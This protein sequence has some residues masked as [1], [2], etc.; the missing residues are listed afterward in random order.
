MKNWSIKNTFRY[1]FTLKNV[2]Y[3]TMDSLQVNSLS[4]V[5]QRI[6]SSLLVL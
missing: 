3:F 2:I 1:Q 4:D 5:L 6:I